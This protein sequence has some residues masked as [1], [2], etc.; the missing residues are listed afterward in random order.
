MSEQMYLEHW[1]L[2]T[3][4]FENTPDCRFLYP[5]QNHRD[6]L[7]KL[8]FTIAGEKGCGMLTG[9][10]GCGKTILI[11]TILSRLDRE[12]YEVA[13]VNYP[14]FNRD[15]FLRDVLLQ[16]GCQTSAK[17]R[18]DLFRELTQF[19][20]E[21]ISEG[22]KSILVIDEAQLIE[23]PEVYEELRLLLNMQL[24]DRFLVSI[25][26]VGQPELREELMLHPQLD[27]QIAVK[28]HLHRF[29]LQDTVR[30]VRH[31]L[32]VA[33]CVRNMFDEE[34]FYLIYKLSNGV[35]RRINNV[36]DMCLLEGFTRGVHQIDGRLFEHLA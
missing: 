21:K 5:S 35:P 27:Q 36:A 32:K 34:A 23:C 28:C 19:F 13:L 30:Y 26:L 31:R 6:S 2:A 16:F 10:Y 12:E 22:K 29:E 15:E 24:V 3:R 20:Y 25:L 18:I 4:P 11:R 7:Q 8:L 1:N 33:G 17:G 14:V 9:E